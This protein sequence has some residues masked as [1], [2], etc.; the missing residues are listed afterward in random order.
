MRFVFNVGVLVLLWIANLFHGTG[1]DTVYHVTDMARWITILLFTASV[2][3]KLMNRHDLQFDKKSFCIFG[4]MAAVFILSPLF[5]GQKSEVCAHYVWVF[6]L[7]YLLAHMKIDEKTMLWTGLAYGVMGF[8]ILY[9]FDFRSTLSGWNENSIAMIGMHSFLIMLVP[10]F[11]LSRLRN[12][13]ILMASALLFSYLVSPTNSRSGILFG[14]VAAL[15]AIG[16]IP[17]KIM[18]G[19]RRITLLWLLFPLFVAFAVVAISSGG[20]MYDLNQWSYRHF[21]KSIFNGRDELWAFGFD[22]LMTS[23]L[24]GKGNL[25][26]V[27]WHNSAVTCLY[28]VGI[29][30]YAFWIAG[31]ANIL[32]RA[33]GFLRDYIVNGCFVCFLVLYAQQS[34]EL[35][36]ITGNPSLLGYILLGMMLGRVNCLKKGRVRR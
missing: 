6:C 10:F 21:D 11:R 9:I 29:V 15:F 34:V 20:Y 27:N 24:I 12:K 35:G 26:A 3:M 31:L 19:N 28:G 25:N 1:L 7:I 5:N 23:P 4:G 30:G 8:A 13:L 17:R 14:L 36:F 32:N 18:T 33:R 2:G 22:R 16:V